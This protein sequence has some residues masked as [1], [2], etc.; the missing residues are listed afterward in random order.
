MLSFP[1]ILF[2]SLQTPVGQ[3]PLFEIKWNV[4]GLSLKYFK[5]IILN[6]KAVL[7]VPTWCCFWALC[8]LACAVLRLPVSLTCLPLLYQAAAESHGVSALRIQEGLCCRG[9]A[10]SGECGALFWGFPEPFS[11]VKRTLTF[12]AVLHI[13]YG[14][15]AS[16]A[17]FIRV[18]R[19]WPK[20]THSAFTLS[21]R[22]G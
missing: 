17:P 21:L 19:T 14:Y 9:H 11:H 15:D 3:L 22:S 2:F 6:P 8:P 20:L 1:V 12:L 10:A 13:C 7:L 18:G 4:F 16:E 5:V